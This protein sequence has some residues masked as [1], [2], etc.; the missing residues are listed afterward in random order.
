ML[1]IKK[2]LSASIIVG[3]LLASAGSAFAEGAVKFECGVLGCGTTT[4]GQICDTYAANTV[5]VA[6]ACD[7]TATPGTG[8]AVPCGG[9]GTCTPWGGM[10]RSDP[11]GAYC[12]PGF[13][14][15]VI[16][17]CR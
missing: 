10:F 11:V 9:G 13:G 17:T 5:P 3:S 14:N 7:D 6:I 15:D 2:Y 16:V 1:A 12:A 4:L 8:T